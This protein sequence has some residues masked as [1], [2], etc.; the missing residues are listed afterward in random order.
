MKTFIFF[1]LLSATVI[2]GSTVAYRVRRNVAIGLRNGDFGDESVGYRGAEQPRNP[3]VSVDGP[4]P[5]SPPMGSPSSRNGRWEI[6]GDT[7]KP[8]VEGHD[9]RF[10]VD[11]G[12]H[13]EH[14]RTTKCLRECV[15]LTIYLAKESVD[16]KFIGTC[17]RYQQVQ[18]CVNGCFSARTDTQEINKLCSSSSEEAWAKHQQCYE[19]LADR[20]MKECHQKCAWNP[21]NAH[22]RRENEKGCRGLGCMAQCVKETLNGHCDG[23]GDGLEKVL[24]SPFDA[25][26]KNRQLR[27]AFTEVINT[28]SECRE[29]ISREN[30]EPNKGKSPF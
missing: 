10:D 2:Y 15:D 16:R 24:Y 11:F 17:R 19:E 23:A 1:I 13:R 8:P 29:F 9:D 27:R 3:H 20:V 4:D 21:Y 26:Q 28:H 18:R 14:R 5:S 7:G 30:V 12:D 22:G 6:R 25:L